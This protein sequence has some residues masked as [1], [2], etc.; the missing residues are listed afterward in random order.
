MSNCEASPKVVFL[1][2]ITQPDK[3]CNGAACNPEDGLGSLKGF[4]VMR[5]PSKGRGSLLHCLLGVVGEVSLVHRA[6]R[7]A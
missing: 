6:F 2:A 4:K 1:G 5:P 7:L 3:V